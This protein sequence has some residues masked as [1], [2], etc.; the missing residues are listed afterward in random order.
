VQVIDNNTFI[1]NTNYTAISNGSGGGNKV[2][3]MLITNTIE[4]YPDAS[5][6]NIRLKK[7]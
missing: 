4:G 6:Y 5:N 3:I 7:N 2:Q 1:I